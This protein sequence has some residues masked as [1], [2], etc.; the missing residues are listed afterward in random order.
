MAVL[1]TKVSVTY[2]PKYGPNFGVHFYVAAGIVDPNNAAVQAIVVAI[3]NV[4]RAVAIE[5][6]L[7]QINALVASAVVGANYVSEDKAQFNFTDEDSK[8][9]NYKLPGPLASIFEANKELVDLTNVDVI[10]WRAAIETYARGRGGA[11]VGTL[12]SAHRTENRK[13]LKTAP[14]I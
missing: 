7:T 2:K 4:T 5:I 8:A 1:A 10:A 11:D 3:N 13:R 14:Q 12:I 6:E 9:H